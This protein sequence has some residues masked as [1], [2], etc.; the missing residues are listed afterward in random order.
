MNRRELLKQAGLLGLLGSLPG[1]RVLAAS[2]AT[3]AGASKKKVLRFAHLTDVHVE[4]ELRAAEGL[5]ACLH[6]LQSQ[7]EA[8]AF[9]FSGGDAVFD[10]LGATKERVEVQWKLWHEVWKKENSL[11]IEYCIGNHDCWG[12]GEKSDPLYGKKF[13]L[14]KMRLDKPYRSFDKAEWHFI[15]LD[16]IHPKLDGGWYTIRLDDEQF[17]WLESDL[18]AT[19]GER[20]VMVISHAPI[21]SAAVLAVDKQVKDEAGYILGGGNMHTDAARIIGLFDRHPNVRLCLSGHIHLNEQVSYNGVTYISNGAV[22]GNWW[23]GKHFRTDNGYAMV[24]LYDDGTF[25]NEYFT[26]GWNG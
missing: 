16:S 2:P 20:P 5:A 14:D 18:A 8:P 4:P 9:I 25:D 24:N 7:K 3:A 12:L 21:L 15:V 1:L 22:S 6:H 10:S 19:P 23:N 26:Y 17:A 11:P 13:A